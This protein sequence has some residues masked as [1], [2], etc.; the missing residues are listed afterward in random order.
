MKRDH[1]FI[2]VGLGWGAQDMR[3]ANGP[4]HLFA[5]QGPE[6][7]T[8]VEVFGQPAYTSF[9]HNTPLRKETPLPIPLDD[10]RDRLNKIHDICK[11]HADHVQREFLDHRLP[12]TIGGDHSMAIGTWGGI[13]T[14]LKNQDFGLIWIDAHLDAHTPETTQ[15]Q[16]IHGMPVAVLLGK[17]YPELTSLIKDSPI[18]KPENLALIGIRS[19]EQAEL[20]FL[21]TLGVRIFYMDEI[22]TRG[23]DAVF[24][25]AKAHVTSNCQQYG[26][27]IDID[28]FDPEEAPG[29]GTLAADG[30]HADDVLPSLFALAQDPRLLAVEIAEYNP[31]KDQEDRTLSLMWN[32]VSTLLGRK[33]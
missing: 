8:F 12:I 1:S 30:L 2:G 26:L 21:T 11:L 10:R 6:K 29:T 32:L 25:D 9:C 31:Q 5:S 3:T 7:Q 16:A 33:P 27:S 18:L 24:E 17:G 13:A 23:F 22:K 15:T 19:Y 14:A 20:D 28:A 4:A